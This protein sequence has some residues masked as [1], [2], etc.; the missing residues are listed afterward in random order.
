MV[1]D[2]V[3]SARLAAENRTSPRAV[4][5]G[6]RRVLS[7]V[8]L[9]AAQ[10]TA[11]SLDPVTVAVNWI[12]PLASTMVALDEIATVTVGRVEPPA[13]GWSPGPELVPQAMTASS[14]A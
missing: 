9:E 7:M 6:D 12:C 11:E 1:A 2:S 13:S 14:E 10:R 8:P 5:G 4:G 3:K